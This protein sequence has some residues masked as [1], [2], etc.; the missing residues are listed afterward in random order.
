MERM[1]ASHIMDHLKQ[2]EMLSDKHFGFG[3]GRGTEN[4]LVLV[5]SEEAKWV[6]EGKV[7][8]MVYLDFSKAFHVVSHLLLP[9]KLQLL[10]FCPIVI[11]RIKSF[12]IGR[13]MS[14]SISGT[15]SLSMPVTS[16]VPQ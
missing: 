14:V 10:G 1:L 5:Y 8:D 4:Q 6:D 2:N 3:Q 12:L 15:S 11:L 16:G 13:T 9:D 7:V